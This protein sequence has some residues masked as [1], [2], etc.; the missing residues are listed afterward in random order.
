MYFRDPR[1]PEP[2]DLEFV[3]ECATLSALAIERHRDDQRIRQTAAIVESSGDAILSKD[4]NGVIQSWNQAAERIYGYSADEIIGRS[5][6]ML[7]PQDRLGELNAY[8]SRL[9]NGERIEHFETVRLAKDGTRVDVILTLSPV[10][11]VDKNIMQFVDVQKNITSSKRDR[12]DL[13]ETRRQHSMLLSNLLGAAFRCRN[14]ENFTIEFVSD[15]IEAVSG[16]T[17]AQLIRKEINWLSTVEPSDRENL[18]SEVKLAIQEKRSYH[19]EFRIRHRD[20]STRWLWEQGRGIYDD[21]GKGVA[22]EGY[23]TD[24]TRRKIADVAVR[25]REQRYRSVIETANSVIL[26]VS[27]NHKIT[28]WNAEAE[29]VF[30]YTRDQVRGTNP[31]ELIVAAD[32][33]EE[34]IAEAESVNSGKPLR[35]YELACIHRDGSPRTVLWNA[36]QL[37]DGDRQ[38]VGYIAVGLDITELQAVQDKLIQSERLASLGQMISVIA[39]ESRNALQRIQ[40]GVDMLGFEMAEDSDSWK[41]LQRISRAKEDLRHLYDELRSPDETGM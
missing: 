18:R 3:S 27:L 5:I 38:P 17:S 7:I 28:E 9:K 35:A 15:G 31:Y 36:S 2:S 26:C 29:R 10:H 20:G 8:Q 39:H 13:Q 23:V 34:A 37:L 32:R 16:Y 11:D 14:D 6:T 33:R 4:V 21:D 22:F 12:M 30:G 19:A 41:D 40:V 1:H 25:D 24:I